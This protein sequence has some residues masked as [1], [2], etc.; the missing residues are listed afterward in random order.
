MLLNFKVGDRVRRITTD[1]WEENDGKKKM[2][3]IGKV[4]TIS[5]IHKPFFSDESWIGVEGFESC[6][7]PEF[8]ENE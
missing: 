6:F 3:W 1:S 2:V 4:Y 7:N 8:F 5:K